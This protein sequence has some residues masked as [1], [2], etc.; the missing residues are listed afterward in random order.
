MIR[1]VIFDCFGVLAEEAWTPYRNKHFGTDGAE[2]DWANQQMHKV[3]IGELTADE[4]VQIICKN[5]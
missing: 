5:R 1:G 2:F 3:S 4:F